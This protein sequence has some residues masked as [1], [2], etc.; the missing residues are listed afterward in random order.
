MMNHFSIFIF[1]FFIFLYYYI[2]TKNETNR[3]VL[4]FVISYILDMNAVMYT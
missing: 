2:F 1:I 4:F 3:F